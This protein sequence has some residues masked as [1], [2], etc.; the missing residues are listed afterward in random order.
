MGF[1]HERVR[2]ELLRHGMPASTLSDVD[3]ERFA[4]HYG[5][6]LGS[7]L[8]VIEDDLAS[9]RVELPPSVAK[10]PGGKPPAARPT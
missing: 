8:R 2:R 7:I 5:A 6:D 3:V 1:L 4:F 10:R 9:S